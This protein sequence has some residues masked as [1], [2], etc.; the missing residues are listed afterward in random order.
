MRKGRA[1]SLRWVAAALVLAAC[2]GGEEGGAERGARGAAGPPVTGG[3]AT[4][5]VLTD[6]SGFNPVT[7]TSILTDEVIKQ[8]LFTPLVQYDEKLEVRPY[9]AESWELSDSGVTF[10]L[11]DDVK[12]HD[13]RP[14]TAEDV[15]FTFDL[16]KNPETASLLG[17]AYMN[18][19]RS[20]TV[21]D[22]RTIRFDF[23]APHAQALDGFWWA[24]L[25]KHLLQNVPPAQLLQAPYNNR[26]VG[27]GPFR[28]VSWERNQRLVLDADTSFTPGLGGRPNLD[29]VVFRIIPEATTMLTEIL[30]GSADVI[31]WTLLPDQ[32][33]Q[34][35]GQRGVDL[36]HFPSRE[37][38][39]VGWNNQREPFTDARVRRALAMAVDRQQMIEALLQGFGAPASGMIPPWS[40]MYTELPPLP[41]DPAAAKR[42]LAEAGW[43]DTNGDGIL[44][45]GGRP[46]RFTLLVNAANRLHQDIA[47]VMQ[48]QLRQ[49]GVDLQLRTAEFQTLLQQHKARDYDAVI[50]NWTLDTFKVDPTPLF[51]CEEARKPGS[52][53][54][55]GYCNAQADQLIQ[56]GLRT[57]DPAQAKQT[58]ARFSEILQQDQ[59]ITFLY[60]TEDLAAVGPRLEGVEM[61]VRSKLVNVPRWWI[62]AD[63]RR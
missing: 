40:P 23:V 3:T 1:S 39:Y 9:L 4:I 10:R 49:A 11:R 46:L 29:R 33:K 27:S 28:F 31:G 37:F 58:W 20:A 47:T 14:V 53:N 60:W 44:E 34:I 51:S 13:G 56:E 18:M 55:A 16:A 45:K 15:K 7:N 38:T 25:P 21:V 24:P 42:L 19:V 17:S 2:G 6:F 35:E 26:P 61:D 30:N 54:R 8:M 32:A 5:G 12:W 48:Q 50:S 22:P 63:R 43:T 62:P 59:P 36:R 52:A 57:M 41:H